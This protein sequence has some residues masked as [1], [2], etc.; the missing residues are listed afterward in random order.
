MERMFSSMFVRR[1]LPARGTGSKESSEKHISHRY[2]PGD[3][4]RKH[5]IGAKHC[6]SPTK[7]RPIPQAKSTISSNK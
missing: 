3:T 1:G 7:H 6:G 2:I 5:A 4:D